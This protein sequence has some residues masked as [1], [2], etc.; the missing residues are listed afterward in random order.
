MKSSSTT[1]DGFRKRSALVPRQKPG[2]RKTQRHDLSPVA[3]GGSA[4]SPARKPTEW[5]S[6]TDATTQE[7]NKRSGR[8]VPV[9]TWSHVLPSKSRERSCMRMKLRWPKRA[10]CDEGRSAPMAPLFLGISRLGIPYGSFL[11]PASEEAA[12]FAAPLPASSHDGPRRSSFLATVYIPR[13]LIQEGLFSFSFARAPF[14]ESRWLRRYGLTGS[15]VPAYGADWEI[16][17]WFACI[18]KVVTMKW[19]LTRVYLSCRKIYYYFSRS[20]EYQWFY[21]QT[22]NI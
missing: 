8:L 19:F 2:P 6:S 10:F 18:W 12:F 13:P 11:L 15:R 14:E 1:G 4:W 17:T 21:Q 16:V 22:R 5:S 20:S 7:T 3:A 9:A